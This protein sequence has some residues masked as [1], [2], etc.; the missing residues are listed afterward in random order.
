MDLTTATTRRR[1]ELFTDRK[2]AISA[3]QGLRV[4]FH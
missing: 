4:T 1:A 2:D 3:F